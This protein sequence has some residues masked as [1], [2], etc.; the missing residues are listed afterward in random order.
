M[1]EKVLDQGVLPHCISTDLTVPGRQITVHSMTE[2]MTRFLAMGFTFDQVVTMSTENPAKAVGVNDR[3]GTLAIGKQADLSVLEIRD[4][5]W[6][7]YDILGDG[8]KSDK[9]V[10]PIMAI[11]KGEVFEAGWGPRP[12]GWEPD[13]A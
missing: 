5:N 4:G 13:S 12:W 9:A 2:M 8:K 11:K 6:M 1:A 3:L 10:I 7:V